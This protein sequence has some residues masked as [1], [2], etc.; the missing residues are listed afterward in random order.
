MEKTK[1]TTKKKITE[2]CVSSEELSKIRD[3]RIFGFE[4]SMQ[5]ARSLMGSINE[6]L[7]RGDLIFAYRSTTPANKAPLF[8]VVVVNDLK[9]GNDGRTYPTK[10]FSVSLITAGYSAYIPHMPVDYLDEVV[11]DLEEG[12]A[13]KK[14]I[15]NFK[16]IVEKIKTK[17][18][19]ER[20]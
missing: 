3:M 17:I 14:I 15:E 16:L 7:L 19:E 8:Q 13:D 4:D 11:G 1:K 5:V 20:V 9:Y 18:K 10:L 2:P 6:N 12:K